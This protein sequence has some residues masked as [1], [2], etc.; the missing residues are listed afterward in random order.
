[1]LLFIYFQA[2]LEK[3]KSNHKALLSGKVTIEVQT[4]FLGK[5]LYVKASNDAS[6]IFV[7]VGGECYI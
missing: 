5:T 1:M 7:N 6:S 4:K 2:P 3:F